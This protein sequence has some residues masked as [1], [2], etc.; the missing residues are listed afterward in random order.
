M[1][2]VYNKLGLPSIVTQRAKGIKPRTGLG[3]TSAKRDY[4]RLAANR[5]SVA[6]SYGKPHQLE[7]LVTEGSEFF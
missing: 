7:D 4:E 2:K 1:L 6:S 3:V 5:F